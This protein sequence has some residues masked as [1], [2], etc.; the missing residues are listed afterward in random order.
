MEVQGVVIPVAV[1]V[2]REVIVV[3]D[4]KVGVTPIQKG[5]DQGHRRDEDGIP[6][7]IEVLRQEERQLA[8]GNPSQGEILHHRGGIRQEEEEILIRQEEMQRVNHHLGEGDIRQM[9][10]HLLDVLAMILLL[11][12][13][14]IHHRVEVHLHDDVSIATTPLE[15]IGLHVVIGTNLRLVE[16]TC[17]PVD[18]MIAHPL[19]VDLPHLDVAILLDDQ[20]EIVL[21][22]AGRQIIRI[23]RIAGVGVQVSIVEIRTGVDSHS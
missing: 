15:A 16:A 12:G 6:Q 23:Q 22:L 9:N 10:H 20:D 7:K 14:E 17:L 18:E 2:I 11:E 21:P 8:V 1:E 13:D 4:P 3:L 5:D 19:V